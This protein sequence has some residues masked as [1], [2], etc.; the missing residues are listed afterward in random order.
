M[1]SVNKVDRELFTALQSMPK[2]KI[3]TFDEGL[4]IHGK[5][6]CAACKKIMDVSEIKPVVSHLMAGV[7]NTCDDCRKLVVGLCPVMCA[8]CKE[9]VSHV[10]P[11]KNSDGFQTM[12]GQIYHIV[13]CP[14]CNNDKFDGKEVETI[15]VEKQAYM[16]VVLGKTI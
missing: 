15:F 9:I 14:A 13:D 1:P 4:A 8:T 10:A 5:C 16:R 11:E 6:R 7:D 3:E 2:P 12:A